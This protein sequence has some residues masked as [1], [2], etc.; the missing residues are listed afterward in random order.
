MVAILVYSSFILVAFT[1]FRTIPY[2]LAEVFVFRIQEKLLALPVYSSF[3]RL[4]SSGLQII[5]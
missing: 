1:C 3:R 4:A 5:P 2:S